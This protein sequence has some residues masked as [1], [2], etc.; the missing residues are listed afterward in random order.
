MCH[1]FVKLVQKQCLR[2]YT[3]YNS[4][5]GYYL[6]RHKMKAL[7]TFYL[8]HF[9]PAN[10]KTLNLFFLNSSISVVSAVCLCRAIMLKAQVIFQFR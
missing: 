7:E 8:L 6:K 3:F 5:W 4:D 10:L 2:D 1:Q 9:L